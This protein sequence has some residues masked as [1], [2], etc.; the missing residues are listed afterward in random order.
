MSFLRSAIS[1]VIGLFVG[2]WFQ[3]LTSVAILAV[4]WLALTR[5][6]VAG[7]AFAMALALAVQLILATAADARRKKA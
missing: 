4:G 5:L 6:H 2:D 1:E 7:L 3:S